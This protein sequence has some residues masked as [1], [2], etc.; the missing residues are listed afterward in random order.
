MEIGVG[1]TEAL[2]KIIQGTGR[3]GSIEV[4]KDLAGI[5]RVIVAEKK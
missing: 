5:E 3:Y 1:Q 2:K 4:L